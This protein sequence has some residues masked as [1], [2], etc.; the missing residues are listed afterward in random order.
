[1]QRIARLAPAGFAAREAG[2]RTLLAR[3]A[4]VERVLAAGLHDPSVWESLAGASSVGPGRG[5]TG[6]LALP[7]SVRVVV[8]RMRRGGW[9]GPMWR[10]RFLGRA[11]LLRNL[12]VPLEA[13]RRG[14][15]T[16]APVAMLIE[17]G[18]PGLRRA[19]L[20]V[21]EIEGA[22]DLLSRLS[23]PRGL[24]EG[25][26]RAALRAVKE[27]HDRGVEHRDLNLGNLLVRSRD[28]GL[29]EAFVVDLDRARLHDKALPVRKRRAALLRMERSYLKR[30]GDEGPLPG[31]PARAWAAAYAGDDRDLGAILAAPGVLA[32]ASLAI[33]RL[34]WRRR[35]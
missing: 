11:R 6:R 21:E 35:R 16:A 7:G 33:H 20:A 1:M 8:K 32:R 34:F 3:D 25:E 12:S 14:V 10:D 26:M 19:F 30:F 17:E 24:S 9:A 2:R 28:G 29:P 22:E 31:L 23:G 15:S 27:M 18:P 4:L 13:M 5:G